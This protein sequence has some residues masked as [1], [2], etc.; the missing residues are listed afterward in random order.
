MNLLFLTSSSVTPRA[1]LRYS[2]PV[3]PNPIR[4]GHL[5]RRRAGSSAPG[6]A[7]AQV[8][9]TPGFRED[10][11]LPGGVENVVAVLHRAVLA[12]EQAPA[13][14]ANLQVPFLPAREG[15]AGLRRDPFRAHP[16]LQGRGRGPSHP[17]AP[18]RRWPGPPRKASGAEALSHPPGFNATGRR[19]PMAHL[20]CLRDCCKARPRRYGRPC[21]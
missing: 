7:V 9:R 3:T 1:T 13:V 19:G 5:R 14:L 16:D 8:S 4:N 10:R 18:R 17:K 12:V 15:R 20:R 21:R 2:A 6:A 11:H